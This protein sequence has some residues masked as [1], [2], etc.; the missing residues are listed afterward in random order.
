MDPLHYLSAQ[1]RAEH[2]ARVK[3]RDI[4]LSAL[5]VDNRSYLCFG[6]AELDRR[7]KLRKQACQYGWSMDHEVF[8][9]ARDGS[10]LRI[11]EALK[12]GADPIKEGGVF[13]AA[14]EGH[15]DCVL[16]LLRWGVPLDMKDGKGLGLLEICLDC[17]RGRDLEREA[18]A[19]AL[20]SL[21]LGQDLLEAAKSKQMSELDKRCKVLDL[22]ETKPDHWS[23]ITWMEKFEPGLAQVRANQE[24]KLI[25]REVGLGKVRAKPRG[26]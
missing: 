26:I 3:K 7:A 17:W 4:E 13:A 16:E 25:E 24:A 8:G 23:V 12:K 6:G 14:I 20:M 2:E 15:G 5:A 10:V 9:A 19:R 18:C 22:H 11:R 1:E 21:G